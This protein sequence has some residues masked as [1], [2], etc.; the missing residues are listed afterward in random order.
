MV[1]DTLAGLKFGFPNEMSTNIYVHTVYAH[2]Q[3]MHTRACLFIHTY[4]H[5]QTIL[6]SKRIFHKLFLMA[7][8]LDPFNW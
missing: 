8:A 6:Q 7:M 4:T 2:T 5:S 1:P 3:C